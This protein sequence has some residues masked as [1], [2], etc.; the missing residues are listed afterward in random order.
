MHWPQRRLGIGV[1]SRRISSTPKF[2]T[3]IFADFI[4]KCHNA[5]NPP[6]GFWNLL[7]YAGVE[8]TRAAMQVPLVSSTT[9]VAPQSLFSKK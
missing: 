4:R 5:G 3:D 2:S 7:S 1:G 9:P 6:E 8:L